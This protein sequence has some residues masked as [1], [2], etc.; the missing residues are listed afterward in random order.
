MPGDVREVPEVTFRLG[1]KVWAGV[2]KKTKVRGHS[3]SKQR[4]GTQGDQ[5]T[6]KT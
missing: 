3:K 6:V 5:G 2:W 4:Q 1:F